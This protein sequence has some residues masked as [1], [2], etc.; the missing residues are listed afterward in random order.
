M[1]NQT[2]HIRR[3]I[4]FRPWLYCFGLILLLPTVV[5]AVALNADLGGTFVMNMN[6]AV[7]ADFVH[8]NLNNPGSFLVHYYDTAESDYATHSDSSFYLGN[9]S[10]TEIPA[11]NL[12]HDIT[13]VSAANP[14]GQAANRHVLSTTPDFSVDPNSMT[15]T[16]L[17]GMTGVEL[18]RG[19]YSGSLIYGD[20]SLQYSLANR[21]DVWDFY[22][23]SGS[24]SGWYLQNNISF[25]AAIY[26]LSNITLEYSDAQNWR[27]AGYL[28]LTP[29]NAGLVQS[30]ALTNVGDFC[31]GVGNYAGCGQISSIP[32]PTAGWLFITATGG[33]LRLHKLNR[34]KA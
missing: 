6:S 26:E 11:V 15:G 23:I 25:P 18:Y 27:M 12:L 30:T 9:S 10:H 19:L 13:P 4:R 20:Y 21:S 7:L 33:W 16:G 3:R 34:S 1:T 31:L 8:G 28:L 24:P 17:L 14:G 22:G 5:S 32:I 2:I 29:E